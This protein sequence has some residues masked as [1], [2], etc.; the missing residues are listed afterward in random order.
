MKQVAEIECQS[1]WL[2]N[3]LVIQLIVRV[4]LKTYIYI[5]RT[6]VNKSLLVLQTFSS[7]E[8]QFTYVIGTFALSFSSSRMLVVFMSRCTY[9]DLV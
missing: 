1:F 9:R 7:Q 5:L 8:N 6:F 3:D 4:Q 2:V